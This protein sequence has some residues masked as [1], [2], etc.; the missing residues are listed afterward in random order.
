MLAAKFLV[1][2]EFLPVSGFLASRFLSESVCAK[3]FLQL[4]EKFQL[5]VRK[6]LHAEIFQREIPTG[7][8]L[9]LT[10]DAVQTAG[11]LFVKILPQILSTLVLLPLFLLSALWKDWI[12]AAILLATLPVAPVLLFLIGRATAERNARAWAELQKL[13]GAFKEILTAITTLKI[14]GRIDAAA[15]RL[16][17]TSEKSSAATLEVLKLA[18]VSSFAL[19]LITTLSIA[20]VAV[21]LGLRLVAGG[22]EFEAA[23]FLLLVTPEFFA[24]VRRLGVM[25]HTV[26]AARQA[27]ERLEIFLAEPTEIGAVVE[28]L[29][30]PPEILVQ[31]VSFAYKKAPVLENLSLKIPA[32]KITAIV[33]ESGCGKSTLIKLLA[34]LIVP[35]AGEIFFSG[36]PASKIQRESFWAKVAYVPQAP[37]LFEATL[38]ENFSMFNQLPTENLAELMNAL[39]LPL[40]LSSTKKISRGQL[41]RLGLVRALLKD[42]PVL[43]L[44]EPTAGLDLETEA[45]VLATLK[46]FA[47]RR[48]IVIATHRDAVINFA[49]L[50]IELSN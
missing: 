48:T 43:L 46:K 24:P 35:T 47:L 12:T 7:E 8:L 5:A 11:E 23:L 17:S 42:S 44:D 19:E 13:N 25:F 40:D 20:L 1:E 49:E 50:V 29:R 22:V 26:I 30:V 34:G 3:K 2:F 18:F 10:F 31:G 27:L 14:F 32:G 37:H 39:N 6:K 38:A 36:I 16:K 33:G 15:G 45:K 4:S 28:K 41:Q 9:T 21:T